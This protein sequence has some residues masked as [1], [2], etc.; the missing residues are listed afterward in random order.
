MINASSLDNEVVLTENIEATGSIVG[1]KNKVAF[2]DIKVNSSVE[3]HI[4]GNGNVV[5][6]KGHRLENVV[7]DI[8]GNNNVLEIDS[9]CLLKR[10]RFRIGNHVQADKCRVQL[11]KGITIEPGCQFLIYTSGSQVS[12]GDD[13]MLSSGI[14]FRTG[15]TP[16]L[17]FRHSTGEYLDQGGDIRIG[18][19]CWIGERVYV[20]KRAVMADNTISA[21][22]SVLSRRYLEE[23]SVIAGNPAKVVKSDVSWQRNA[24][25]LEPGGLE[26]TSLN[27]FLNGYRVHD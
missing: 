6:I 19:H 11:S 13:C 3:V 20:T 8:S 25:C 18:N 4:K 24:K 10:T 9:N 23:Y 22:C 14:T 12:L 26:Q 2:D 21:A 16:H 15:E 17:L 27:S 5:T 7:I 1:N